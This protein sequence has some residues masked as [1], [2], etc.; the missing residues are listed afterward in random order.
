MQWHE[1]ISKCIEADTNLDAKPQ[2]KSLRKNNSISNK[3]QDLFFLY[4]TYYHAAFSIS[5]KHHENNS[6]VFKVP[7]GNKS[8]NKNIENEVKAN[9]LKSATYFVHATL[10]LPALHE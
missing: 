9:V 7:S 5:V 8:A 2:L 3:K 6:N 1:N 10:T 4:A